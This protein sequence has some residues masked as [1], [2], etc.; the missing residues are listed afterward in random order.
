MQAAENLE[1][2]GI[3]ADPVALSIIAREAA[4]SMRDAMSMLDQVIAWNA[5]HLRGEDVARVLG[6]AS[7]QVLFD[8][9]RGVVQGDAAACLQIIAQLAEQG[10]EMVHVARDLLAVHRDLVVAKVCQDPAALLDL[11]DEEQRDVIQLA[12]AADSD[13]LLRLH[14][15]FSQGFDDIARSGHPRA[16][17]EMLLVRLARRPPL[18]PI[19]DLVRRLGALERRL[20]AP[21]GRTG[22]SAPVGRPPPRAPARGGGGGA[23]SGS[24]QQQS[25]AS[26]PP[27]GGGEQSAHHSSD[28]GVASGTKPATPHAA[29]STA[30]VGLSAAAGP[31]PAAVPP[32]RRAPGHSAP[33]V[34]PPR[35]SPA[36]PPASALMEP[37]DHPPPGPTAVAP[38]GPPVSAPEERT[39]AATPEPDARGPERGSG[40]S[41]AERSPID[42]SAPAD[43]ADCW[44][45]I[46]EEVRATRPEVAAYLEHA[47]PLKLDQDE[48]R[49]VWEAGTVFAEQLSVPG[50]QQVLQHVVGRYFTPAT[51]VVIESD[52]SL[53]HGAETLAVR[54]AQRRAVLAR[55]AMARAQQHADVVAAVNL[56]GARIKEIKLAK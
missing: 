34:Q 29:E 33:A 50:S 38:A 21:D 55:E 6:V 46:V 11:A 18:L 10:F 22:G 35:Q 43:A 13:D 31:P 48:V 2:E 41:A 36:C 37:P 4:G 40:A 47:V 24:R 28:S 45:A 32:E 51:R 23:L 42:H 16:A 30:A 39:P 27:V 5:E 52:S 15:G 25:I 49:V 7:R 20:T 53:P 54:K 26:E 14:H 44:E 1:Q 19:D 56:L 17:L 3:D 8:I 12:A 9:A